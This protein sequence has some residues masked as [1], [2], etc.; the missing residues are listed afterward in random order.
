MFKVMIRQKKDGKICGHSILCEDFMT[1]EQAK[2]NAIIYSL[3]TES[4]YEIREYH[5]RKINVISFN[6]N[7]TGTVVEQYQMEN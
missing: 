4:G 1:I 6:S 5:T 2:A 3:S 7:D